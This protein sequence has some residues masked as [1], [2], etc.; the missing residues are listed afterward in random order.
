[1][2]Q[3]WIGYDPAQPYP[4]VPLP[5]AG[6]TKKNTNTPPQGLSTFLATVPDGL[7]GDNIEVEYRV[8]AADTLTRRDQAD[9]DAEYAAIQA[10]KD[11]LAAR[12]VNAKQRVKQ[13]LNIPAVKS[14]KTLADA[15]TYV[16]GQVNDLATA[17]VYMGKLTYALV[18]VAR[19]LDPKED[20]FF[21]NDE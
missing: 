1:M 10:E 5:G 11:K 9:I 18:N 14:I 20:D 16:D 12:P 17:K 4:Q 19:A 21:P 7:R 15:Q 2:M 8:T 6:V 13:F 3:V